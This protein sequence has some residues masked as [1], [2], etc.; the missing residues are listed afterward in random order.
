MAEETNGWRGRME[1][2]VDNL[3]ETAK[4]HKRRIDSHET[5]MGQHG[6]CCPRSAAIEQLETALY[7]EEKGVILRLT[8][9]E[10][11]MKDMKPVV[12]SLKNWRIYMAGVAAAI[13]FFGGLAAFI[14]FER[15]MRAINA[16]AAVPK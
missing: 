5:W 2:S 15:M 1:E 10:T 6:L 7:C 3:K 16:V 11:N 4:E 12:E 9:Q 8:A 13:V 14:G